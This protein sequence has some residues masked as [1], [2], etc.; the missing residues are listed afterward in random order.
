[1][2]KRRD[3]RNPELPLFDLPL[4]ESADSDA[5]LELDP[6]VDPEPDDRLFG[7][8]DDTE[9]SRH[10]PKDHAE[11]FSEEGDAA[12]DAAREDLEE[13]NVSPFPRPAGGLFDQQLAE[14]DDAAEDPE[15]V[16]ASIVDRLLSGLADLGVHLVMLAVAVGSSFALG[17][18]PGIETW[19][20]F[21]GLAL[22][23]SFL[24]WIIPLAFWGQTPGM[25][26][27]GIV[28]R[29]EDGEPL[30]FGQAVLRWAGGLLTG[31]LAG[32]PLLLVLAGGSLSDR[33][34][35]SVTEEV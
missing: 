35:D 26:W 25:A 34:S 30:T 8:P 22:V 14:L 18:S 2:A 3:P 13:G 7:P 32:T 11:A 5:D 23:F 31:A 16:T 24:Y 20:P 28:S 21:L 12:H 6:S 17:V 19:A 33:L 10:P 29:C 1:M 27:I 9:P 15:P 4:R